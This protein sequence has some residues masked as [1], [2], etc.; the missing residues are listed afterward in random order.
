MY[1]A[2]VLALHVRI[3]PFFSHGFNLLRAGILAAALWAAFASALVASL[4]QQVD[5]Q[6]VQWALVAFTPI[7]F[8]LGVGAAHWKKLRILASIKRLR[9]EYARESAGGA[10]ASLLGP[11]RS[12]YATASSALTIPTDAAAGAGAGAAAAGKKAQR[13]DP[14]DEFYDAES[15]TSRAFESS[16]MAHCAIRVLLRE[17]DA[18]GVRPA[19]PQ[20]R[21]APDAVRRRDRQLPARADPARTQAPSFRRCTG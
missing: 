15:L 4:S 7:F 10:A 18:R 12:R 5:S 16:S 13:R 11:S 21:D 8:S 19:R 9:A 1:Q 2:F 17:K 6:G 14:F 20:L 3:L